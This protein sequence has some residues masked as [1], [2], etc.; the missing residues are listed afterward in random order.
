[1]QPITVRGSLIDSINMTMA[2]AEWMP[3]LLQ[4]VFGIFLF[5]AETSNYNASEP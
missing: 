5:R 1:M 4:L 3:G 2:V